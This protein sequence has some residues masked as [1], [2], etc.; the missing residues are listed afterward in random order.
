MQLST[1][2]VLGFGVL[3]GLPIFLAIGIAHADPATP[4]Q[5][6]PGEVTAK[7]GAPMVLIP[8]GVFP[9]GVPK[10]DRDGGRDEY[11]RHEV[12]LDAYYIDKYEVTNG[13]Y[14]EF[15]RATGH[16]SPQHPKD[17]TRSLWRGNTMP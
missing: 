7:D 6:R 9:M 1:L 4:S 8:A 11:P 13:R 10:G 5:S 15:V 2:P 16:R 12:F 14:L 3:F 17:P